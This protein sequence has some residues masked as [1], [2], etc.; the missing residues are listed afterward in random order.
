MINAEMTEN[1]NENDDLSVFLSFQYLHNGDGRRFNC[2]S[3][4]WISSFFVKLL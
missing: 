2:N 4:A 3:H 1:I